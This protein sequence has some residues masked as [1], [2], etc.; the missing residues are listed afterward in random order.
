MSADTLLN[1]RQNLDTLIPGLNETS[2]PLPRHIDRAMNEQIAEWPTLEKDTTYST[3]LRLLDKSWPRR[4]SAYKIQGWILPWDTTCTRGT[5]YLL[6]RNFMEWEQSLGRFGKA[7][8]PCLRGVKIADVRLSSLLKGA[9]ESKAY[10]PGTSDPST[11][12]RLLFSKPPAKICISLMAA[13]GLN[14]PDSFEN[15]RLGLSNHLAPIYL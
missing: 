12:C 6:E 3:V 11:Q 7:W 14:P 2:V 1:T 4:Y 15:L 5:L 13:P 9:G 8:I 10:C